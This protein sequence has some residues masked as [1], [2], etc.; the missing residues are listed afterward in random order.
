VEANRLKRRTAGA[1]PPLLEGLTMTT[2][3]AKKT[4]CDLRGFVANH[5]QSDEGLP[6]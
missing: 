3:A 1:V 5:D 2:G 6:R 4:S